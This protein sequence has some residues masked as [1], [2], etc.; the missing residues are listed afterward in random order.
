MSEKIRPILIIFSYFIVGGL[1]VFLLI[2]FLVSKYLPAWMHLLDLELFLL[3]I[4]L[5][6]SGAIDGVFDFLMEAEEE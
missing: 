1:G 4:I 3:W 6:F 5:P 2:A